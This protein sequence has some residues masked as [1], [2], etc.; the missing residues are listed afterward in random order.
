MCLCLS[1]S[2]SS[3]PPLYAS[4]SLP[5]YVVTSASLCHRLCLTIFCVQPQS[6]SRPQSPSSP[7]ARK[8]MEVYRRR[9]SFRFLFGEPNRLVHIESRFIEIVTL[10]VCFWRS[11]STYFT[12]NR[13]SSRARRDEQ[14]KPEKPERPVGFMPVQAFTGPE[15]FNGGDQPVCTPAGPSSNF[16]ICVPV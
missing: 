9:R 15:N 12:L 8:E 6:Q 11:T 16:N 14:E 3:P 7:I 1:T 4:S 2:S 13:A 5:L 10:S